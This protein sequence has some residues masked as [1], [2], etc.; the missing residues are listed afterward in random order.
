ML[1]F[2]GHFSTKTRRYSTTLGC[3]RAAREQWRRQRTFNAHNLDLDTPT[4]RVHTEDLDDLD[5]DED[6]VLIIGDWRYIGRGHS[7]GQALYAASIS[8]DL[9]ESRRIWRQVRSDEEAAA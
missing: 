2:R 6:V 8:E 4:I 7:P 5:I 1:G 3:L 9:A